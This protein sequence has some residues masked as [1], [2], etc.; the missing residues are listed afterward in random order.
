MEIKA[1]CYGFNSASSRCGAGRRGSRRRLDSAVARALM[2]H[3]GLLGRAK[4]ATPREGVGRC[5]R[6]G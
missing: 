1:A 3:V 5:G 4:K 2:Q 6:L